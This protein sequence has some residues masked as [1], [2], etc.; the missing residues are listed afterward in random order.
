MLQAILSG[1]RAEILLRLVAGVVVVFTALPLHEV[2][3]GYIA[4]RL[5][6]PT[7]KG[8][9]RLTLNPLAHFDLIGTTM[10]LILGFGWAKPVPVNPYYFKNRKNGMALTALAGPASNLL[11]GTVVLAINKLVVYFLPYSEFVQVLSVILSIVTNI[12]L[13]LA[14]FNLIPIPPLDGSKIIGLFLPMSLYGRLE[15][16]FARYQQYF[17]YGLMAL[18][19]ILPRLR[20]PLSFL[21]GIIDWPLQ[22]LF[23][24]LARIAE[25]LT[26]WVELLAKWIL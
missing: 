23:N 25:F 10:L 15:N 14:A 4:Y 26:G 17:L 20:G 21:G 16:W 13:T 12:N 24:A 1:D 18:I 3:H 22:F 9:G 2:A 5:G 6:D 7:A 11:L 8:Q 19:F